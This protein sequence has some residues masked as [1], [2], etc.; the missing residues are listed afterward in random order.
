MYRD[1]STKNSAAS[2]LP[3]QIFDA[4]RSELAMEPPEL[5]AI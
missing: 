1:E 3:L 2:V 5:T 4:P